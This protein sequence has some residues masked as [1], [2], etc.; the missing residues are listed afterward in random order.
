MITGRATNVRLLAG[1]LLLTVTWLPQAAPADPAAIN[2][3][4]LYGTWLAQEAHPEQGKIETVFTIFEDRTFSGSMTING[5][6]VWTYGGT[7]T[8]EDSRMTWY[9]SRG[10]L[11]LLDIH[12]RETDEILSITDE[13]LTYRSLNRD[14]VST[15]QRLDP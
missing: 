7:W 15:L 13:T 5:E 14:S 9:Y 8:L 4:R 11:A 6:V 10:S 3:I 2:T 1:I 12:R